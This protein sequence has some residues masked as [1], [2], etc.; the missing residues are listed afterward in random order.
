MLLAP[1][2]GFAPIAEGEQE[3]DHGREAVDNAIDME[4]E[5]VSRFLL[6][7]CGGP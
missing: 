4:M 2:A 6:L 1:W 7:V 5:E 3:E